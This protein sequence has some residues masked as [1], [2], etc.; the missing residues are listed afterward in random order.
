MKIAFLGTRGFYSRYSGVEI[1]VHDLAERLAARGHEIIVYCWPDKIQGKQA[2]AKNIRLIYIPTLKTKHLG[3][4]IHTL[5]SSLHVLF[6]KAD[7]VHFQAL[8]PSFFCFLP[9]LCGKKTVVTIHSLDWQRR[10]W[11]A[12][13]R[14]FLRLCE[15]TAVFF[16]NKTIV[17]SRALKQY[18]ESRLSKTVNYIPN[19]VNMPGMSEGDGFKGRN[20]ILF[21]GRLTPEKRIDSLIKAF[22]A[23]RP[24]M[25]LVIAGGSVFD[26]KYP[27]YLRA[28]SAGNNRIKFPG[29]ATAAQLNELYRRAYMFILPS[30]I[31]G[32]PLSLLEAMSYGACPLTADIP[33]CQEIAGEA[34]LYFK[35]G[36]HY[37]LKDKIQFLI[38]H[39]ALCAQKGLIARKRVCERYSWEFVINELD[40]LY[41]TAKG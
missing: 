32:A 41:L 34:A 37:D 33:G 25:D 24:D 27:A 22:N 23:I 3:T 40:S 9:R 21:A 14:F 17:V 15:F 19:A 13:A 31:E 16:P 5:F 6:I 38:E 10:K 36:D 28:I 26:R 11:N 2:L 29:Q 4:F 30:E 7:I 8:G 39:P 18:Y 20:I 12:C 35:H 1:I